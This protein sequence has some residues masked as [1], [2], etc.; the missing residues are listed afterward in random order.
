MKLRLERLPMGAG[1][2]VTK[3]KK[4]PRLEQIG[5]RSGV[6]VVCAYKS[7]GVTALAF[8]NRLVAFRRKAHRGIWVD[9]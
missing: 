4:S 7:R 8:E 3:M 6:A 9:H 1:G 5:L 2:V